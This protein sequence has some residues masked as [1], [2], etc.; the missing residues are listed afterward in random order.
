MAYDKT[1][2]T[3]LV[4]MEVP[5]KIALALADANSPVKV[6]VPQTAPAALVVGTATLAQ[7][8]TAFN[9]LRTKL[10]AA[11]VLS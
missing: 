8:Q 9:D 1:V 7:T 2:Y 6:V 4:A 5:R 11:G 3:K 10:I